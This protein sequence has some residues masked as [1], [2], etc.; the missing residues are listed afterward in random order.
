MAQQNH[1]L[2][3]STKNSKSP[4]PK[5]FSQKPTR[6]ECTKVYSQIQLNE[7]N[8]EIHLQALHL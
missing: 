7:Q 8:T 3:H 1:L 2:H 5:Y 6:S 4:I